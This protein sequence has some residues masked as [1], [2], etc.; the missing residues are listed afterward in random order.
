MQ[1]QS[2]FLNEFASRNGDVADKKQGS[3]EVEVLKHVSEA[4]QTGFDVNN[5]DSLSKLDALLLSSVF[6]I[7]NTLSMADLALYVALLP[8]ASTLAGSHPNLARY[9]DHVQH[10]HVVRACPS[11]P[12]LVSFFKQPDNKMFSVTINR[13]VSVPAN[14]NKAATQNKGKKEVKESKDDKEAKEVKETPK[15]SDNKDDKKDQKK[16]AKPKKEAAPAAG[17]KY[18][19]HRLDVKVGK[20]LDVQSHPEEDKWYVMKVDIAEAEPRTLIC[21]LRPFMPVEDI[22]DQS[23]CLV[24]NLK[25]SEM[26][27]VMSNGRTLVATGADGKKQLI[28]PPQDAKIGEKVTFKG[29]DQPADATLASKWQS[30]I[31]KQL[32][33]NENSIAQYMDLDFMTSAGPCA[34]TD[35]PNATIA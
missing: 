10:L 35:M 17:K 21:G 1:F 11:A 27:G 6:V 22:K 28:K 24:I 8:I 3:T 29:Q 34:V 32:H 15:K 33:T 31:F 25:A 14:D 5:K 9:V 12:A 2:A 26:K 20:V 16:D 4:L 19:I 7:N 23:V 13:E 18:Q 30:E